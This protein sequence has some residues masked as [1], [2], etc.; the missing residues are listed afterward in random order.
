MAR[1]SDGFIRWAVLVSI[2]VL[3]CLNLS[4]ISM[5]SG[6][7]TVDPKM[8]LETLERRTDPQRILE[9]LEQR[10]NPQVVLDKLE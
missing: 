4:I 2:A 8:I 5:I 1:L 10:T 3:A 9:A 7:L 6:R